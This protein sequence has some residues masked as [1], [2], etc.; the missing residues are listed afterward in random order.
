M[1]GRVVILTGGVGG[2]KLVDGVARLLAPGDVTA[3]VNIGDDFTHVGLRISPDIDTLLYTLSGQ[4]NPVEGWGRKDESWQ[5]M[6]ALASL[7]GDHWF[8]LGDGDLAL[9][10]L[11]TQALATGTPL[12]A[13]IAGFAR[14][15]GIGIRILPA[16]DDA[17]AT[18]VET[19]EGVLPFQLYFVARRCAPA[20]RSI[21]FEGAEAARP[22]PGVI[23]A[24]ADPGTRAILIAPSNP[25][26]S[27]D[28]ILAV[29]G[30]RQAL[31]R[32]SAPVVAVSPLVGGKAVKGPT[33]KI[34]AELGLPV[35]APAIVR[36]YGY[37]LSGILLDERDDP[38]PIALPSQ[39][40]DTLMNDAGDRLR[41]A[42][43]AL[44]FADR[45][46]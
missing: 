44:D 19:D 38:E 42:R 14:S 40:A 33:A 6:A 37:I 5:F 11:R 26:L 23:E 15:W 28:P 13:V 12:S 1:S 30:I 2:A 29:P 18:I 22:A 20:V 4:A 3:I 7:G 21:R 27:V 35:S 31:A 8:R 34:M 17:L 10:V 43:A 39:R 46:R 9:H 36:H 41:V 32:A 16:T 24:I 25:F 45:L